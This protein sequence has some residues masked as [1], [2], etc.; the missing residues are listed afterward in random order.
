MN[1]AMSATDSGASNLTPCLTDMFCSIRR[2]DG[3]STVVHRVGRTARALHATGAETLVE[4]ADAHAHIDADLLYAASA[5][6]HT[7]RRTL[8]Q[9]TG[10]AIGDEDVGRVGAERI[11]AVGDLRQDLHDQPTRAVHPHTLV[12]NLRWACELVTKD[13]TTSVPTAPQS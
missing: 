12:K 11:L 1:G 8:L 3:V 13:P 9:L 2:T 5:R 7:A 10:Q 6:A 4:Q